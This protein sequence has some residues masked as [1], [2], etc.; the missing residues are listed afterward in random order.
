MLMNVASIKQ[1]KNKELYCCLTFFCEDCL[2][3]SETQITNHQACKR[4][5]YYLVNLLC[6]H[7][8]RA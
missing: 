1:N 5:V 3:F 6:A 2:T 8:Y 7:N 4:E